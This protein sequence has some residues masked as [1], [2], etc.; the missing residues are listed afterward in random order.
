DKKTHFQTPVKNLVMFD[1]GYTSVPSFFLLKHLGV[2]FIMRAKT[3]FTTEITEIVKSGQLDTIITISL[4]KFRRSIDPD[5]KSYMPDINDDPSMQLRVTVHEL[6][7]GE[8]E[9]LITSLLDRNEFSYDNLFY[10]YSKRWCV[11]EGLKL[12]K[13]AAEIENFSGESKIAIEQDFYATV[14]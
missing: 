8:K 7:S 9:I 5:F 6:N 10:L 2:D 13:H 11:E 12:H 14:F 3:T 1:R 4:Y